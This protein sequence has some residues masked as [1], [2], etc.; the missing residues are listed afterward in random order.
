MRSFTSVLVAGLLA[1]LSN[2]VPTVPSLESRQDAGSHL[3]FAHFMMGIV[4]N[5]G[6][7]ADYDDDMKRAKAAG[8]DAF[9]LNIGTDSYT[10]AQLGYAY[11][12]AAKNG[13]KVFISFDFNWFSPGGDA[14]KVGAL[15]KQFG[16]L[17]A[18]LMVDKKVFVSSFAGDG[19]NVGAVRA[20]SGMDL[21]VAPNFH[22]EQTPDVSAIDGALN[23][24]AWD[25]DGANKAPKP[26]GV[27]LTTA[28]NDAKY[29]K[30]LGGKGFIAPV[31]PW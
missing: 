13:M 24:V 2:A 27:N 5:R 15:V 21:Y 18:Q 6:S 30:W 11:E 31:S 26:G 23:W 22:P 12:S 17:P 16:G 1:A 25:S 9:A 20:A 29:Q 8:I 4:P 14:G 19:L 28:Q 3:V 10:E 7:S